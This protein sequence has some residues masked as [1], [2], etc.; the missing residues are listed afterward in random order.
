MKAIVPW[1]PEE[2]DSPL[3][4]M[5]EVQAL[6]SIAAGIILIRWKD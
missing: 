1:D 4:A 2:V 6:V 3:T 5:L